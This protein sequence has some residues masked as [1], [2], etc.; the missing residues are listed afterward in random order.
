M[1]LLA[2]LTTARDNLAAELATESA[3][4]RPNYGAAGR[5]FSW[6]EYR[7]GLVAQIADLN[8]Q[9]INAQGAVEISTSA[10]G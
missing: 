5:S 8:Q 1:T 9:V 3:N 4:P 6:S 7:A 10:Y 2:S